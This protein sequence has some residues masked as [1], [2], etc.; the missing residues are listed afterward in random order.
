MRRSPVVRRALSYTGIDTLTPAVGNMHG[1]LPSMVCGQVKKHLDI[2]RISRIKRETGAL[3]TLH[4]GSGTDDNSLRQAVSAGINIVHIN[5]ELRVAWRCGLEAGL[6]N[7]PSV[8]VHTEV[9]Q[10]L[11][12]LG[13]GSRLAHGVF[14]V[15]RRDGK[16]VIA[17]CSFMSSYAGRHPE[18]GVLLDG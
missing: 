13:Y 2:E 16:R 11:S 6:A 8:L 14:E 4:G 17:K 18:Y 12:G 10:E 3:L 5:T 15:L 9:P 7:K 1:L